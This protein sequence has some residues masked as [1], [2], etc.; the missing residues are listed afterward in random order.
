[1]YLSRVEIDINNRKNLRELR[2]LGCYHGW[3]EDAFIQERER[4]KSDRTRKLWRIDHIKGK[5]YLLL[6]SEIKPDVE[7]LEK[8]GVQGSCSI[9]DYDKLLNN[10]NEG[11]HAKFR[12]K[13]NT[14]KAKF[15]N[16]KSNKRG[17]II[18]VPLDELNS[19][20]MNRAKINGFSVEKD[21]FRIINKTEEL[22]ERVD[23]DASKKTKINLVSATY[24]GILTITDLDLFKNA[25]I[26]GIGKK[27]AYGFGL[28]TIIPLYE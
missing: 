9:K 19:F 10:L 20:F 5:L 16:N 11:M 7:L 18:P 28:L 17:K 13:L 22:F 6:L 27:K 14:V 4:D 26:K 2:H 1:M 8:Y 3:I 25:L 23:I 21:E 24:D 15:D 12:I